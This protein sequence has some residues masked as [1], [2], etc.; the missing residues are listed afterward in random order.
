[1]GK[2][3]SWEDRFEELKDYRK[4]YGNCNVPQRYQQNK[5]LGIWV[6]HQR[7]QHKKFQN[8]E[9]STMTKE[10]IAKLRSIG[11]VWNVGNDGTGLSN[12]ELWEKRYNELKDYR[13][14]Y[15]NCLVPDKYQHNKQL[16]IW[17]SKQRQNYKKHQQG[18]YS[19]MT[20]GRIAKLKSIGFVWI[21]GNDGTGLSNDELWEKRF[22]EL[23]DCRKKYGNCNVPKSYQ[24]NKQLGKWVDN[25]RTQYK[26]FQKGE[27]STMTIERISKLKSIDFVWNTRILVDDCEGEG[28]PNN[29]NK[30]R[31]RDD[32]ACS[33]VE[34]ESVTQQRIINSPSPQRRVDEVD[35]Q[36]KRQRRQSDVYPDIAPT[37][38]SLGPPTETAT[39][40]ERSTDSRTE[41]VQHHHF[42]DECLA[43]AL[44]RADREVWGIIHS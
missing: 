37:S 15:G 22:N 41:E 43:I 12:D 4:K 3:T 31:H 32:V 10:R 17:V 23:K 29:S 7:T 9:Y 11:F 39:V 14:K 6:N 16:G 30:K 1:M 18:E 36:N 27:Y 21:V 40:D 42:R 44:I 2:H 35:H 20:K 19:P 34:D 13:K 5:Q 25:Q 24:G 28:L 8:G 38:S 26:K 33:T